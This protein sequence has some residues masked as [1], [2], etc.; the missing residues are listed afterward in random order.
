[1]WFVIQ[2]TQVPGH[3]SRTCCSS[4]MTPMQ[5]TRIRAYCQSAD[6]ASDYCFSLPQET[7]RSCRLGQAGEAMVSA[8]A[9]RHGGTGR[10]QRAESS[11]TTRLELVRTLPSM[12]WDTAVG[13]LPAGTGTRLSLI[14]I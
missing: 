13:T 9:M 6:S 2:A 5:H 7:A 10:L 3:R 1:M 14:H 12:P 8:T 4:R 11:A